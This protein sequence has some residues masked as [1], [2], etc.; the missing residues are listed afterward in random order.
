[1][2]K[3]VKKEDKKV[4]KGDEKAVVVRVPRK[5]KK[6]NKKNFGILSFDGKDAE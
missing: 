3:V 6:W 1:M 4:V 5:L 2:S